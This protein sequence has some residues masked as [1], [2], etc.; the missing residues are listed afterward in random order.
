MAMSISN[1]L[2][3]LKYNICFRFSYRNVNDWQSV[4]KLTFI[5]NQIKLCEAINSPEELKHWYTMLAFHLAIGNDEHKIRLL[6]N[7]LLGTNLK[8]P[9]TERKQHIL[10]SRQKQ[11]VVRSH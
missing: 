7:D 10:V 5:E 11:I 6:L 2:I 3:N 8:N 1:S 4:A 9:S